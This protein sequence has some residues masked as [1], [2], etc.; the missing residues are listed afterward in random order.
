MLK[1]KNYKRNILRSHRQFDTPPFNF[2]S[3]LPTV[4]ILST[5]VPLMSPTTRVSWLVSIFPKLA[6]SRHRHALKLESWRSIEVIAAFFAQHKSQMRFISISSICLSL[7]SGR[8]GYVFLSR[9]S[10]TEAREDN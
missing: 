8:V 1:D 3:L 9:A 7:N 6:K 2:H 10:R 5:V 4:G